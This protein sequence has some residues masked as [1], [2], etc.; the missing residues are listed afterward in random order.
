[1]YLYLCILICS[2]ALICII[3]HGNGIDLSCTVITL[4]NNCMVNWGESRSVT[5]ILGVATSMTIT[6]LIRETR[7]VSASGASTVAEETVD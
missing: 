1:M 6:R 2:Y 4:Y 5:V 7:R 3:L